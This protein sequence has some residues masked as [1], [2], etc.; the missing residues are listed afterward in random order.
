M[1]KQVNELFQC[2]KCLLFYKE[3]E[4]A[5]K[6]EEWDSKHNSCNLEIVKHAV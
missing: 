6:C 3:K 1:V 5:E 2:E 4:W